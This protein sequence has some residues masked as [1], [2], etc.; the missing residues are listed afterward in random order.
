MRPQQDYNGIALRAYQDIEDR[1][2]M[3]EITGHHTVLKKLIR[4][5]QAPQ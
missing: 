5:H 2:P 3:G 1:A 4:D